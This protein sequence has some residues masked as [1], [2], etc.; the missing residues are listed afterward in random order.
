MRPRKPE[1]SALLIALAGILIIAAFLL[2]DLTLAH[3]RDLEDGKRRLRHFDLM[4]AEHTARTFE[5]VDVLLREVSTD[6][7]RTRRDW[8]KWTSLRGWEYVAQRHSRSMVQLRDLIVFDQQGNQRFISTLYPAPNVN[9]ADRPYFQAIAAGADQATYGP[10][11]GRNTG[12]YTYGIARRIFGEDGSFAGIAYGT[13]EPGYLQDFCWPNRLAEDFDAVLVNLNGEVIASCRPAD[14]SRQSP[15]L[16]ARFEEVLFSGRL[17]GAVPD[18]G[19]VEANGLLISA[20]SVPGFKDLR[21]VSAIPEDSLLAEWQT[22]LLDTILVGII[23]IALVGSGAMMIRRQVI[24]MA[25]IT[26]QLETN[27]AQLAQRVEEAT[28]ELAGQRDA[29]ERAN[30]AKSRFLAAASHDLRQPLHALGLFITDLQRQIRSDNRS[31]LPHITE[32]IAASTEALGNLLNSLLDISRLDVAGAKPDVRNFPLSPLFDRL[33]AAFRPSLNERQLRLRMRPGS[34]WVHS[35]P[36]MLERMI[37]NLLANAIRYTPVG[38]RILIGSRYRSGQVSIEV[39]DSG[40]GIAEE[41]QRAIFGEFFQVGNSAR[42]AQ[43]GLGLGL[44]IVDRLARALEIPVALRS[45]L[46]EGSTFSLLLKH[47]PPEPPSEKPKRSNSPEILCIGDSEEL[48]ES[49]GQLERWGY[50]VTLLAQADAAPW[51]AA[52]IILADQHLAL[53]MVLPA[54]IPLIVLCANPAHPMPA[55]AHA[56]PLPVRPAKLRALIGQLQKTLSKSMP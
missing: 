52:P 47:V 10:Y 39:R 43:N 5:A 55:G 38:G 12:N 26:A 36:V 19:L 20:T 44:S 50:P 1:T 27:R 53:S 51:P 45:R 3:H 29:A 40:I 37:G 35:D 14:L 6:L 48:L 21:I 49:R 9:V 42:E 34:Y 7:S 23:L 28:R 54:D 17:R 13:I 24:T 16:G 56:L 18:N 8:T 46:G 11:I 30:A 31:L 15:I 33:S 32:Q 2:I 41:N 25:D 4:M 22:R